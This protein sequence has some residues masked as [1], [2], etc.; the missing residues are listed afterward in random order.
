MNHYYQ[1]IG[2]DWFNYPNLYK[3]VVNYFNNATFVEVGSWKGRSST[4]MGV[5]IYNSNKNI[6]FYCV[7]TWIADNLSYNDASILDKYKHADT[8]YEEFLSNISPL[9]NIITPLRMSSEEASKS[10]A[11][12]SIDFV[13]I[14][15]AH[16]YFNVKKDINFWYSKVKANGIFA[17]HDYSPHWPGVMQA[18]DEWCKEYNHTIDVSETCWI[19]HKK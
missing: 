7:D 16:D 14:D 19:H 3:N 5:E 17:G 8:L 2:E 18:V 1:T 10:F 12:N 11:D 6:K 13:F 15:A 4:Y 9:S